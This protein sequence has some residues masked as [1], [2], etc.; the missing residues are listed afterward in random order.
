M[1]ITSLKYFIFIILSVI[2]YVFVAKKIR[3]VFLI[4]ISVIFYSAFGLYNALIFY[5]VIIVTYFFSLLISNNNLKNRLLYLWLSILFLSSILLFFK[6]GN[7]IFISSN[8]FFPIGLSFLIFKSISYE[9]EIYRKNN[10][11]NNTL[12][13]CTFYLSF[14][15]AIRSGPIDKPNDLIQQI[16]NI[17]KFDSNNISSGSKLIIW[18]IFKKLVIADRLAFFVNNVFDNPHNFKGLP[19][20]IATILFSLQI[21][22]DFSAYTD[23]ALGTAQLF[24]IKLINNFDRPYFSKSISDFW[25]RWH[26]SLSVWLRDY[27]FLP[28]AYLS[29]KKINKFKISQNKKNIIV[30]TFSIFITMIIAGLWHGNTINFIIWGGIFAF[31]LSFSIITKKLRVKAINLTGINKL[32]NIYNTFRILITF[33]LIA[34]AWIFFR[35]YNIENAFYIINNLFSGFLNFN[36]YVINL[37]TIYN[38]IVEF[39]NPGAEL[40]IAI[41]FVIISEIIQYKF[42]SVNELSKYPIL[43]RWSVNYFVIFSI[44]LFSISKVHKFIYYNF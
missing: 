9:I 30:Y 27:L 35:A 5:S 28:L 17:N 7:F 33:C 10:K 31:Y 4:L 24:G 37:T 15:P 34:F 20:V 16:Q 36:H 14:F 12:F 2:F 32:T 38:G 6:F 44:L 29:T 26:I 25:R 39:D 3:F 41:F 13:N 1:E 8:F 40:L 23:I 11:F 22:Y 19:L 21:F 18:G 42:K 43:I